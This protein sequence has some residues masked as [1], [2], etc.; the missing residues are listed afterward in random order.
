MYPKISIVT[1]SLNSGK[2]IEE[3]IESVLSQDYYNYEYIVVDG[4]SNDN[5]I[6]ILKKHE[7]RISN[8]SIFRW[9]S[10]RDNGQTDAINKGLKL[11]TGD[12]FAFLNAD[13]FYM[14][15]VFHHLAD[16]MASNRDKGVIYGNQRVIYDG[17][18]NSNDLLKKPKYSLAF[19]DLLYSNQIYGPASFYNMRALKFTGD[20]DVSLFH[21]MDWDMYLRIARIM[22]LK[23]YD[24]DIAVFR[25]SKGMKSPSNPNDKMKYKRSFKEAHLVSRKHGGNY[26]SVKLLQRSVFYGKYKYYL[27]RFENDKGIAGHDKLENVKINHLLLYVFV[28]IHYLL[29]SLILIKKIISRILK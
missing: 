10:E 16:F 11:C 21:W 24:C 1:P 23:Y 6:E 12:W 3:T 29:K 4:G 13:D 7:E 19:N 5:T 27:K 9:I 22:P 17:L 28:T 14:P 26:F 8:G 18:D 25:I 2:Y 20:F 15:R